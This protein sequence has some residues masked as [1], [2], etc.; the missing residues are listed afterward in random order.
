MNESAKTDEF[1]NLMGMQEPIQSPLSP[2]SFQSLT[3]EQKTQLQQWPAQ[4]GKTN[5]PAARTPINHQYVSPQST[6]QYAAP[7]RAYVSPQ[8]Y[9]QYLPRPVMNQPMQQPAQ[10]TQQIEPQQLATAL[11]GM[12]Y[13]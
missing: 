12:R 10:Q 2:S 13:E 8:N 5:N 1:G 7:Q 11:R 9:Q 3:P 4:L 6:H